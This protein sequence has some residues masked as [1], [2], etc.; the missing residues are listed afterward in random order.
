MR[1]KTRIQSLWIIAVALLLPVAG[2]A[3]MQ[4]ASTGDRALNDYMKGR[5]DDPIARLQQK[6]DARY[7]ESAL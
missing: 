2:M 4:M 3:M 5:A 1:N 7:G 6:V